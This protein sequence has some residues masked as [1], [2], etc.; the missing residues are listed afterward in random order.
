MAELGEKYGPKHPA[1]IQT[2]S[3]LKEIQGRIQMEVK[4]IYSAVKGEYDVAVARERVIRNALNQQKAEVMLSGQHEV[5][6][7]ILERE[8]QS[9]RQ[10]YEMFLKRMKETDIAADIRTSNIYVADPAIVSLEPVRPKK[11]LAVLLAGLLG[12]FGGLALAFF[13]DY[14]DNSIKSPEDIA[15]H[16][17]GIAYLGFLP[18]LENLQSKNKESQVDLATHEAPQSAFAENIRSIRTGIFLSAAD[19]PPASILVTSPAENEGK[20]AFSINLAIAIAQLGHPTILIDSDLRKPRVHKVFNVEVAKGLS[21]YLVGEVG[22]QEIILPTGIPNLKFI[23]C[24]AVPPNPA[25]LLQSKHMMNLL[26]R[27]EKDGVHVVL[28]SS[29]VMAVT[30]P[31]I[32]GNRVDGVILVVWAGH[33]NRHSARLAARLLSEGKV[34]LLGTVLQ[35]LRRREMTTNYSHYYY[36]PYYRSKYYRQKSDPKGVGEA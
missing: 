36:Y 2:S 23:P 16:L 24:G 1:M 15:Q 17:P 14:M 3:E 7:G 25:E 13:L 32:V 6:Y 33:T 26:E 8:V 20:S 4:K 10:L 21:H 9:N 28:D 30:D 18:V 19:K 22:L 5:Q 11:T 34:R 29:P 12:L 35:R 31:V 27:L